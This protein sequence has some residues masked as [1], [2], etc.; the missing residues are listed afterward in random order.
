MS[1]SDETPEKRRADAE[2]QIRQGANALIANGI[3][4]LGHL[5]LDSLTVLTAPPTI[6]PR[7]DRYQVISGMDGDWYV[8][9]TTQAQIISECDGDGAEERAGS[10]ATQCNSLRATLPTIEPAE[11]TPGQLAAALD[12]IE[13][14]RL[15]SNLIW[16]Q[17]MR[18]VRGTLRYTVPM[19]SKE[20]PR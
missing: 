19:T 7:P 16:D 6:E 2:R 20:T 3:Y 18:E 17:A 4:L 8:L 11:A 13:K 9:D 14:A 12:L 1:E 15:D 10:Y 5:V